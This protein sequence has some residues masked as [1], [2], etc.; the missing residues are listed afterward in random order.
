MYRRKDDVL[1]LSLEQLDQALTTQVAGRET[2]WAKAV[3]RALEDLETALRQH[4]AATKAPDGVLAEVDETRPTLARQAQELRSE[5]DDSL[6]KVEALHEEVLQ[7][8]T[9]FQAAGRPGENTFNT[10]IPDFTAIRRDAEDLLAS[11]EHNKEAEAKLVLESVNTDI[12][13]GD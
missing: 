3:A 8:A 10:G 9:P 6:H 5:Y 2:E 1:G 7:A 13:V 11:L 4:R 12:G